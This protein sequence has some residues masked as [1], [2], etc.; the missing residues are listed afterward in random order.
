MFLENKLVVD[1]PMNLHAKLQKRHTALYFHR[2]HKAIA[3]KVIG[4]YH[5]SRGLNPV[6][7]LLKN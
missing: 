5:T 3:T 4:F 6:D 7:I 2:V 1:S